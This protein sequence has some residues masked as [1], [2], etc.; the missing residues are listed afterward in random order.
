MPLTLSI[1]NISECTVIVQVPY[2]T[3]WAWPFSDISQ[4][5][6][7]FAHMPSYSLGPNYPKTVELNETHTNVITGPRL[8]YQF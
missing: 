4:R 6:D 5:M 3:K 1:S 8:I 7:N 2:A